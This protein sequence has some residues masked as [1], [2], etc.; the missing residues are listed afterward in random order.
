MID[1]AAIERIAAIGGPALV[2]KMLDLFLT[3]APQR[4]NAAEEGQAN[5]DLRAVEAATH[6]LKSSAGNL[7]AIR[8]QELA[9]RIEELA[10]GGQTD[11]L[12]SLILELQS[13]WD[14]VRI[15]LESTREEL[16]P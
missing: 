3:N 6:S 4:L 7:G 14:A 12:G 9:G 1:P 15:E 2:A 11:D 10:D 8:L 5:G 13:E 16:Q